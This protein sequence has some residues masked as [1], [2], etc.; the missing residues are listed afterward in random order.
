MA[1]GRDRSLPKQ[2]ASAP[3]ASPLSAEAGSFGR[4]RPGGKSARGILRILVFVAGAAV[5]LVAAVLVALYRGTQQ[6]PEFYRQALAADPQRQAESS[7]EMLEQASE[8]VSNAQQEGHW[9]ALFTDEQIN[10]WMAVDLVK[11]H[12]D[13]LPPEVQEPRLSIRPE[14]VSLGCRWE[15]ERI[16]T[17]FSLNVELYLA[18]PNT[19]ALRIRGA[20]AGNVPLPLA[21]IL[22]GMTR[23]AQ[24]LDLRLEWVQTAGDPVAMVSFPPPEGRDDRRIIIESIELRPGAVYLAGKTIPR[25]AQGEE[26]PQSAQPNVAE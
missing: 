12:A 20:R 13:A 14:G 23:A 18:Q 2:L 9:E 5:V 8:L 1:G 4:D 3:L 7:R 10:G 22:D 16:S 6:V 21:R 17:V 19:V 15:T 11:N 25:S 26:L 24:E